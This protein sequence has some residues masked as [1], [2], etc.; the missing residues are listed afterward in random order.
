M[1][2]YPSFGVKGPLNL[3]VLVPA[4]HS[5]FLPDAA[6]SPTPRALCPGRCR[7]RTGGVGTALDPGDHV[8]H[9]VFGESWANRCVAGRWLRQKGRSVH[10]GGILDLPCLQVQA[11]VQVR[12]L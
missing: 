6:L 1:A 12:R 5:P 3:R 9:R 4:R 8:V 7:I 10:E 2:I 11:Q